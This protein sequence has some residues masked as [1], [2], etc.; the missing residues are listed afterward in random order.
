MDL[1]YRPIISLTSYD[2]EPAWEIRVTKMNPGTYFNPLGGI[3]VG[4]S[5]SWGGKPAIQPER[6]GM[7]VCIH[8]YGHDLGLLYLDDYMA[9]T[10]P[11][12]GYRC[13]SAPGG[14]DGKSK[15]A[16]PTSAMAH[17]APDVVA[18]LTHFERVLEITN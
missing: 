16:S 14:H 3:Q 11:A 4:E 8:E 7:G 1:P 13:R 18:G 12:F 9:R 5:D 17:S 6:G 2:V 10:G 15:I